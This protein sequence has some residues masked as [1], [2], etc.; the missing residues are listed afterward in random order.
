SF[1]VTVEDHE[2][3]TITCPANITQYPAAGVCTAV[4]VSTAPGCGDHCPGQTVAQTAGLPSG[5]AF[6][7]GTTVNSFTVTDASGNTASCS[8]SEERRVGKNQII[9]CPAN[10]TQNT[11]AGL[12]TAVVTYT[13]PGSSDNCPGH[14]VAQTADLPP[15][16]P[17]SDL[18]TVNSFTVTDASGNTASCSFS[19]TVEDHEN[20][21]I[22]CPANIT[23][24]TDAGL[25]TAVVTY[26]TPGSS[27]N[28]P[29]QTVAQTA[30]L[31]S[32]SA[33]T[34]G[35]TVNSFTVTDASGNTA[36]CSFSVTVEDHEN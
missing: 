8:R 30:A 19:V 29:G 13:T 9:T 28:C 24:N 11:D 12:C 1:S 34:K 6:P 26:T 33:F 27:D 7:K 18:T 25:C 36:S 35:T 32:G 17:S 3:P 10:I 5:S 20:P 22:T 23:Q 4:V 14:T 2:N 15:T 21:T 16:R 31:P